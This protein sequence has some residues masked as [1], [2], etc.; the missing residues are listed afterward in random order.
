MQPFG[1]SKPVLKNLSHPQV[2][3]VGVGNKNLQA[4]TKQKELVTVFSFRNWINC[5]EPL[6]NFTEIGADA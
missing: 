2:D 6:P 3:R 4:G 1:L 5:P